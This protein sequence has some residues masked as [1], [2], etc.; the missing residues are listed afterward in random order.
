[1]STHHKTD[2]FS[3]GA[4][5]S[6]MARLAAVECR[7]SSYKPKKNPLVFAKARGSLVWDVEGKEYIDLCAGFGALP[8]GHN[9]EALQSVL[10]QHGSEINAVDH[11]MGDV[12]PSDEKILFLEALRGALPKAYTKGAV[13]LSGGQ[14][15]EIALKTAML[16]TKKFGFIVFDDAYHGLDLGI[17]PL[18]AREDFRGPFQP[19]IAA[20]NV[21]RIPY[22]ADRAAVEV[23]IQLLKKNCGGLAAIVAEPMQGRAGIVLPRVGWLSML[24]EAAHAHDGLL[25]L[26]EV[27]TGFGRIGS[28][29]SA[30]SVDADL[31]CFGKAIGGGFPIS[32]CFGKETVMNAWPE[33][34]GEALHTGTFFGHPFSAAVG[35]NT[36]RAILEQNLAERAVRVGDAARDYLK[37]KLAGS[38]QVTSIRGLGLMIGIE[39][40]TAGAAATAMDDLRGEGII[41]LPSGSSGSVLSVTPAL[42]I[43]ETLFKTALE[44]VSRYLC[45]L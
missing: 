32:A 24:G 9:S 11:A 34:P 26:D 44:R 38:A 23:A 13:A 45:N 40:R 20:N 5:S 2:T 36:V 14:C 27:F 4:N 6:W 12:Y 8:L 33:S 10:A 37:S 25:I 7:D 41:I 35:R 16:A 1:M 43:E 30:T 17:L 39:C 19:W 22:G 42:N 15:V 29:T 21:V 3:G 31:L 28:L 18:T